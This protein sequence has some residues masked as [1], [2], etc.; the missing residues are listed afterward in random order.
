MGYANQG[1]SI[2]NGLKNNPQYQQAFAASS[3]SNPS[4]GAPIT[5]FNA[6][7]QEIG[8]PLSLA[9]IMAQVSQQQQQQMMISQLLNAQAQSLGIGNTGLFSQFGNA[10]SSLGGT[11]MGAGA[12]SPNS[13]QGQA[14]LAHNELLNLSQQMGAATSTTQVKNLQAEFNAIANFINTVGGGKYAGFTNLSKYGTS[15]S[16]GTGGVLSNTP[17]GAQQIAEINAQL[18]NIEAQAE[19]IP[20]AMEQLRIS[21]KAAGQ[22]FLNFGDWSSYASQ[23]LGNLSTAIST[24]QQDLSQGLIPHQGLRITHLHLRRCPIGW[25]F[26]VGQAIPVGR[27]G[28]ILQRIHRRPRDRLRRCPDGFGVKISPVEAV[29]V[30]GSIISPHRLMIPIDRERSIGRSPNRPNARLIMS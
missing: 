8:S 11:P 15:M 6:N 12:I 25:G 16:F 28:R 4:A 24:F 27:E 14:I 30:R 13:P 21:T 7:A 1:L 5:G 29:E 20:S 22:A 26:A 10:I 2:F 9:Q 18:Q 23:A 3:L 17:Y 19:A